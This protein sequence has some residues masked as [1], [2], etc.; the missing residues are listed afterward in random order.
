[1]TAAPVIHIGGWPGAGKLTVA[2]AL[3]QRLGARLLHNHLMLDPANAVYDRGALGHGQLRAEVRAAVFAH[4]KA[5]PAQVPIVLTDA[6]ADEPAADPLFQ[7]TKDLAKARGAR[8]LA[9]V[10]DLSI[11]ENLRR[12]TD[13]SRHGRS[14]LTDPDILRNIRARDRLFVP[15]GGKVIDVTTQSPQQAAALIETWS[16]SGE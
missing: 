13:P 12:L 14:K 5:L 8:L 2:K 7:P 11:D 6:L 16:Q 3:A 1:M 15:E 4:A 10:L 9:V